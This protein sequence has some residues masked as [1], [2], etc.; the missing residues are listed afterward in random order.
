[1]RISQNKNW[2]RSKNQTKRDRKSIGG[3]SYKYF[4]GDQKH[5][6]GDG[7]KPKDIIT[8]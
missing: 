6:E 1:M 8:K 7:R 4:E 2:R 3:D 5:T